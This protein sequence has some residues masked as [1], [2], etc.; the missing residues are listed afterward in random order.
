MEIVFA[1]NNEHKLEEVKAI[2]G[3][4]VKLLSLKEIDFSE[5]LPETSGTIIGNALQKARTLNELSGRSCFAD[6]TGLEVFELN[7]EPG[8]DSAHYAGPQ[9]NAQENM[10]KLLNRLNNSENRSARF[11]TVIAFIHDG[12]E[13]L[14]EGEVRGIISTEPQGEGGFGYDPIFIPEGFN[15]S[16]AELSSRQKNSMSHRARA[17]EQLK[18][19]FQKMLDK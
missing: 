19:H 11:I 1:S 3:D 2:L 6:D 4:V 5:E 8:V 10:K 13:M 12:V 9:R 17:V 14:F 15:Q 18:N 7:G 16:F